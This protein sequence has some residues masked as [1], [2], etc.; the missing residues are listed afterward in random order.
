MKSNQHFSKK[1]SAYIIYL[2]SADP[3]ADG[4]H[5]NSSYPILQTT[6]T[7]I[8][9]KINLNSGVDCVIIISKTTP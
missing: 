7:L 2:Q 6:Q 8:N 4:Y 5:L 9:Y 1:R 3:I